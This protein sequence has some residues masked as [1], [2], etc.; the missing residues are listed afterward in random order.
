MI[1]ALLA[2]AGALA[3]SGPCAAEPLPAARA[4]CLRHEADRLIAE[5]AARLERLAD[6]QGSDP[7]ALRAGLSDW[8]RA[9]RAACARAGAAAEDRGSAALAEARCLLGAARARGVADR[10]GR[11]G[12][13]L[14]D[15]YAGYPLGV[16]V[17]PLPGGRFR[18]RP[19]IGLPP[20]R[21][22][23]FGPSRAP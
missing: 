13:A 20:P 3:L 17:V 11:A 21:A 6:V 2:M 16:E 23:P 7:R 22:G 15:P 14:P 4:A 10:L 5:T 8:Q 12:A 19:L 1:A 9:A 18:L